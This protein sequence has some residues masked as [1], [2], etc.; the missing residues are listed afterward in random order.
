MGLSG[1]ATSDSSIVSVLS[2]LSVSTIAEDGNTTKKPNQGMM[3][4]L[5]N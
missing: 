2:S 3:K 5:F 1:T 4:M